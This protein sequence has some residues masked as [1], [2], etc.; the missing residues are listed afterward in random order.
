MIMYSL[1][2]PL[3]LQIEI[4]R[5]RGCSCRCRG[6]SCNELEWKFP[7]DLREQT[8]IL[9][10]VISSKASFIFKLTQR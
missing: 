6:H 4:C 2:N 8:K 10:N 5:V 7:G 1:T 9:R 3:T